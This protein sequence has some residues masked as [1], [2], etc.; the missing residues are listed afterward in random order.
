MSAAAADL[1]VEHPEDGI[2]LITLTRE[3]V[4]NAIRRSTMTQLEDALLTLESDGIT[5]SLLVVGQGRAFCAG[6][7]INEF[8]AL[9]P[10]EAN[11]FI[12]QGQAVFSHLA[13]SAIPSVAVLNGVTLGGG[14][15]LALACDF[16]IAAASAR[17]GQPEITLGHL[18]GWG[19]T[20]RLPQLVGR[21]TA[22]RLLLGGHLIDADAA[23]AC[24]L[25]DAIES[26]ATCMEAAMSWARK[27]ATAAPIAVRRI[28]AAVDHG[29]AD[30][31]TEGSASEREGFDE[32]FRSNDHVEGFRAFAE[33]RE[34][35]FHGD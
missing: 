23:L 7:D 30:G 8:G 2:A 27:L 17:F 29:L 32:C 9:S 35:R 31:L 20:Q 12:E 13:S 6:A 22:L 34:P 5:R 1:R 24:G 11:D 33:R 3:R 21:S 26:D 16:R 28:K 18:P 19:G 10:S 15:E 4:L 25:V 14:N